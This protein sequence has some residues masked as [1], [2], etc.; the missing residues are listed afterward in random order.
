MDRNQIVG[1]ILNEAR[2]SKDYSLQYVADRI[3]RSRYTYRDYETGDTEMY[4][5]MFI[6][7]CNVLGLDPMDVALR[8]SKDP[9]LEDEK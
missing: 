8:V 3:G 2:K 5:G 7:V 4:W 1:E 9:R 6:K